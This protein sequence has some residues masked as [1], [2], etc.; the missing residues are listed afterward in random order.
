MSRKR[1]ELLAPAS[2]FEMAEAALQQGCDAIYFGVGRLNARSAKAS[3]TLEDLPQLMR[4]LKKQGKK[5]YLTLNTLLYDEDLDEAL[6]LARTAYLEGVDAV[7]VQDLGLAL[8]LRHYLPDLELHA[9]T[10]MTIATVEEL[11]LIA[12][13][14]F[15]RFVLPR[16][17]DRDAVEELAKQAEVLGIE[18]ELFVQGALCVCTSG[19]C[20]LSVQMG[21]RSANRGECAQPCRL[22]YRLEEDGK[23]I[24]ALTP[25]LSPADLSLEGAM[26]SVRDMPIHSLKIEGRKRH[27]D[28]VA[29][30]CQA[31][32]LA[33]DE[34]ETQVSQTEIR[35]EA[36][37][38]LALSFNRGGDYQ[39]QWFLNQAGPAFLS[40]ARTGH[41][42]CLLGEVERIS[43]NEGKLVLKV[44]EPSLLPYLIKGSVLSLRNFKTQEEFASAPIGE[45]KIIGQTC[46]QVTGFHP[47]VLRFLEA[48]LSAYV[49]SSPTLAQWKRDKQGARKPALSYR[50]LETGESNQAQALGME[51]GIEACLNLEDGRQFLA[52][53]V[54]EVL[55]DCPSLP[56]N[57]VEASLAKLGDS[58]FTYGGFVSE[59]IAG[60]PCRKSE[61][62]RVRRILVEKI[63]SK[64]CEP[65]RE[66]I[67]LPPNASR[68]FLE[69]LVQAHFDQLKTLVKHSLTGKQLVLYRFSGDFE[70][71]EEAC[72]GYEHLV[73]PVA[74][75]VTA[76]AAQEQ[77]RTEGELRSALAE[78][79][80]RNPQLRIQLNLPPLMTLELQATL[81]SELPKLQGYGIRGLTSSSWVAKAYCVRLN[82][83]ETDA[84][85][86]RYTKPEET[87]FWT[88]DQG[89]HALNSVAATLALLWGAQ[90][91]SPSAE[92]KTQRNV[93]PFIWLVEILGEPLSIDFQLGGGRRVMYNK[94]CPVGFRVNGCTRCRGKH[95]QLVMENQEKIDLLC[96]PEESC[97]TSLFD[98][99]VK[100]NRYRQS[101]LQGSYRLLKRQNC[102]ML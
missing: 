42:G 11:E 101:D 93:R 47:Q 17:L 43:A 48:G 98:E 40:G 38:K 51:L 49:Q 96:H 58:Y 13:L 55:P 34:L 72:K 15:R 85:N 78:F 1:P 67:Q 5:G 28:Y 10:Q 32:R 50:L 84:E 65:T 83:S 100:E 52:S 8:L 36:R 37:R 54:L 7:I 81:R 97:M 62:N 20:N 35:A 12:E 79:C 26:E 18:T 71:L 95:Y 6:S 77:E 73:L 94:H 91:L 22:R 89:A 9:S 25:L 57:Q 61:L 23:Q 86:G 4:R 99:K 63:E 30:A 44:S 74:S 53:E 45:P 64:L 66:A 29:A 102:S 92:F 21:G 27:P 88:Q 46:V 69:N 39:A 60:L 41:H 16:E 75:V 24:R 70:A 76:R 31:F 80:Q 33:L 59:G 56:L 82:K 87:W 68:T 19:Q 2:T 3:F 90:S 14:G